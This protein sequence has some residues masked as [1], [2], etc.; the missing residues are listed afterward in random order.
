M[1]RAGGEGLQQGKLPSPEKQNF[2]QQILISK[3]QLLGVL[4]KQGEK[5]QAEVYTYSCG[6]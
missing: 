4:L 1:H 3:V 6:E 5:N 2:P